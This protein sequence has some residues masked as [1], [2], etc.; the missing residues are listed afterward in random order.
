MMRV[1]IDARS[2]VEKRSG[3]G[4]YVEAL[5]R[6][7]V[8][9]ASDVHFLVLRHPHE[10]IPI[11][12]HPRVQELSF[13]GETKSMA[14]V[15]ALGFRHPFAGFDLYHS[16]ADLVP[17]GIQCPYVVTLHD[18]MWIEAPQLASNFL[19]V[20]IANGIWYRTNMKRAILGARAILSISNATRDRIAAL[21]PEHVHK[22]HVV[23]HGLDTS[24][25]ARDSS[26]DELALG[27]IVPAGTRF[28]LIVGQG[29]PYKNHEGMV[30]A[31]VRAT[32]DRPGHK[33][34]LVRRFAR[35]DRSMQR[36]L[37]Q[38]E[39][40]S[41]VITLPHVS[42]AALLALYRKARMLLFVSHYEGFGL[43][44]LEAMALG[45]PVLASFAPAVLEVTGDAALHADSRSIDDMAYK[46]RLLDDDEALRAELSQ[47]G[48]ARARTFS[49]DRCAEATLAV[50]RE[51]IARP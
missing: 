11:L 45:T 44:A 3:I 28:S 30:R 16:P 5:I 10:Q 29:S 8:P 26:I 21:F 23:P 42:D 39:V 38:P 34:V 12:R 18:M 32:R 46:I 2:V 43:P 6:H 31:F 51:A 22:V 7:M 50:Y 19:P 35:V 25:Y 37:A 40:R 41:R 1:V 14:T 47:K 24:R 13:P 27:G 15:L 49:W 48:P 4:N 33:L 17:L 9:L 36:L 20:R